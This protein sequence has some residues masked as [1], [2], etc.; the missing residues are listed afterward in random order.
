M[1]THY[2]ARTPL[3]PRLLRLGVAC[4]TGL[5][6]PQPP[7]QRRGWLDLALAALVG[8]CIMGALLQAVVR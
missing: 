5:A 2:P 8:A 3:N 7:R 6:Q 1:T 4:H